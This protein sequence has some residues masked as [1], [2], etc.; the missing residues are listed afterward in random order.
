[1]HS[2]AF[3]P[4]FY[5]CFSALILICMTWAIFKGWKNKAVRVPSRFSKEPIYRNLNPVRYW[6]VIITYLL[7]DVR[8]LIVLCLSILL[9]LKVLK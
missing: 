9:A 6:G 8:M 5:V 3:N 7:C 1:M 4:W 2:D